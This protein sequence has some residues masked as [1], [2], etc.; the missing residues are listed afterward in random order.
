[1]QKYYDNLDDYTDTRPSKLMEFTK[2]FMPAVIFIGSI[3]LMFM[4]IGAL[5][6]L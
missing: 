5:E 1:M 3:A 4:V 6:T 2:R